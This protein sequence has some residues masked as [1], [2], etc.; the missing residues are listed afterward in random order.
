MAYDDF[1]RL[2]PDQFG[3]CCKAWNEVQNQRDRQEWERVRILAT[4]TVQP[5]TKK[6]LIPK[7]VMPFPWDSEPK[8]EAP[9]MNREDSKKR[10]ERLMAERNK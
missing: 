5:H 8:S 7:K 4:L 3:E 10:F 1:C 9:Q 2:T 6:R